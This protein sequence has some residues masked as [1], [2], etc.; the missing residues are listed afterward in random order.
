MARTARPV[1]RLAAALPLV[2]LLCSGCSQGAEDFDS[3]RPDPKPTLDL[4]VRTPV[5]PSPDQPTDAPLV[6]ELPGATGGVPGTPNTAPPP[7][8][9]SEDSDDG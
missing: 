9:P 2:A 8:S 1:V 4:V 7:A 6:Q 3:N 5:L